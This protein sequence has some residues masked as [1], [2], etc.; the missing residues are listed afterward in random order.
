MTAPSLFQINARLR[1][2]N[3]IAPG[4]LETA[5]PEKGLQLASAQDALALLPIKLSD[6]AL[7]RPARSRSSRSPSSCSAL[8]T[9][10]APN[11]ENHSA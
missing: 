6:A 9:R 7:E 8:Y 1:V 5:I 4:H 2:M 10:S 11:C 3:A